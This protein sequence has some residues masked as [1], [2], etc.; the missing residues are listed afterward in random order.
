MIRKS[1]APPIMAGEAAGSTQVGV[2]YETAN[3]LGALNAYKPY[4]A[5]R[6]TQVVEYARIVRWVLNA[7]DGYQDRSGESLDSLARHIRH[8]RVEVRCVGNK[9]VVVTPG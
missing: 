1:A 5:R 4:I 3:A 8:G 9:I 6:V 2:G 7:L